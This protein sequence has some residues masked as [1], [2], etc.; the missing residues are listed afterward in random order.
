MDVPPLMQALLSE[1]WGH[2]MSLIDEGA[3]VNHK[4][5]I[6]ITPLHIAARC[7]NPTWSVCI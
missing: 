3:K 7:G 4:D 1:E 5:W 6:G 2:A